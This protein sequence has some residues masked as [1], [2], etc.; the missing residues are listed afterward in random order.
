MGVKEVEQRYQ[1]VRIERVEST[2]EKL[3]R[4]NER[5]ESPNEKVESTLREKKVESRNGSV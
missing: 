5:V 2:N 1:K 4:R 3:E